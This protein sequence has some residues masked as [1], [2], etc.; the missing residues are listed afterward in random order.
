MRCDEHA[1]TSCF[2]PNT[3]IRRAGLPPIVVTG[4]ELAVVDPKLA[5]EEV[6]LLDT[7]MDMGWILDAWLEPHEQ[8]DAMRVVF[9]RQKL[10][11]EPR[12]SFLPFR[13]SPAVV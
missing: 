9:P 5:V 3:T 13:L 4:M 1:R 11:G 10:I 7:R 6:Q 2:A 8:R 12:R